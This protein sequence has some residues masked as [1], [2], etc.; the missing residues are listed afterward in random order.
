MPT[1]PNRSR[2]VSG[3]RLGDRAQVFVATACSAPGLIVRCI[4]AEQAAGELHAQ[5][6][7]LQ[8]KRSVVERALGWRKSFRWLRY[9]VD[10]TAASLQ[11]FVYLAILVLC[12]RRLMRPSRADAPAR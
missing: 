3:E 6:A 10:R 8:R 5:V 12:V 9:R 7:A 2:R 11:A 4:P 1:A